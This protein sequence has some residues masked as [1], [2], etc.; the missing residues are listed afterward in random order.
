VFVRGKEPDA[1]V[2]ALAENH[3]MVILS[4]EKRMYPACGILYL[5]GLREAGSNG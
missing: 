2:L 3:G 1:N 4:T 5:N